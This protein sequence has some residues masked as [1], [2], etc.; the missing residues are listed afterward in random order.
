MCRVVECP[1]R[2]AAVVGNIQSGAS[3]RSQYASFG[4]IF[5]LGAY[6][7][8]GSMLEQNAVKGNERL[9]IMLR[10]ECEQALEERK[11]RARK[12]GEQAGTKML[13]PMMLMLLIVMAVI[14]V[15]AFWSM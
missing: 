1:A 9:R 8:L 7:R 11:A 6:S 15:P 5:G 10:E 14:M 12:A 2:L 3:E 13:F 4:R